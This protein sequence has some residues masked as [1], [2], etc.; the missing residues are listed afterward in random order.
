VYIFF[1]FVGERNFAWNTLIDSAE[2]RFY[3]FIFNNAYNDKVFFLLM[4]KLF[5]STAVHV[6]NAPIHTSLIQN[7]HPQSSVSQKF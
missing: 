3:K 6:S 2:F 4:K 7:T 1:S 5:L